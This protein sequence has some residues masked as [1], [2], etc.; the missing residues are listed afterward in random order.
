MPDPKQLPHLLKLLDDD[1]EVVQA[2]LSRQLNSYG[3]S[4]KTELARL[5]ESPSP[6]QR[7]RLQELTQE[8]NRH[9]LREHWQEWMDEP[10]EVIALE[11]A[12]SLLSEFQSG[13]IYPGDL[14]LMLDDLAILARDR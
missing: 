10:N 8:E 6:A 4:L 14:S 9:W 3:S 2:E 5:A 7:K 13:Y 11:K 1:S 12:M